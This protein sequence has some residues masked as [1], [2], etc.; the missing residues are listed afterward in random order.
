MARNFFNTNFL[1]ALRKQAKQTQLD[2]A[3]TLVFLI[4]TVWN[5]AIHAAPSDRSQA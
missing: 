1:K 5:R 3:S 2:F 4:R